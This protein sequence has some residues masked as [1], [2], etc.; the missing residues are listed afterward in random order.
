MLSETLSRLHF[1]MEYEML[2]KSALIL[3]IYLTLC[4][5]NWEAIVNTIV[6]QPLAVM[7]PQWLENSSCFDHLSSL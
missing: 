3:A 5:S 1:S 2:E 4:L 6:Y 7:S